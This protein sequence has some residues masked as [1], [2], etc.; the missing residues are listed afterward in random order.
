MRERERDSSGEAQITGR[1]KNCETD[2]EEGRTE[3]REKGEMKLVIKGGKEE[4]GLG[5]RIE[6]SVR[7]C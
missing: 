6:R 1:N 2:Q 5:K 3:G 4:D 7:S